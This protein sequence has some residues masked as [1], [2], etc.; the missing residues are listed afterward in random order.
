[1]A[2]KKLPAA[3]LEYF[4]EQGK[5]GGT[6]GGKRSLKTM[7]AAAR[8]ARAKKAGEASGAARKAKAKAK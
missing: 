8:K 1:V 3:V 6:I 4:R 7:T 2:K 5:L